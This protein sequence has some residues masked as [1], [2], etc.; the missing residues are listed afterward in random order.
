[1]RAGRL[2]EPGD[3]YLGWAI[4]SAAIALL[5]VAV[6]TGWG[7]SLVTIEST[8]ATPMA[9]VGEVF[10]GEA[11]W[12]RVGTGL[13]SLVL[14]VLSLTV[15]ALVVVLL[16]HQRNGTRVDHLA[17]SM[18]RP[19]DRQLLSSAHLAKDAKRLGVAAVCG[20]GVPIGRAVGANETLGSSW[21]WTQMWIMGP[22]AGKT[23]C[24]CVPQIVSTRGPVLATSNK[25]DL[26]DLTRG[27]RSQSG[28]VWVHDPQGLV[29]EPPSWTW[30]PL[31]YVT[32]VARADEMVSVFAASSRNTDAKT[33]AYFDGMAQSLLS[34]FILA[35]GLTKHQITD[36]YTWLNQ[37]ED[38]TPELLLRKA[39]QSISADLVRSVRELNPKQRDG[40]IGS[41]QPL[42]AWVRDEQIREWVLP[43]D[44]VPEFDPDA[45]VRSRDTLYAISKEGAGS[46]RALTAALTVAV[47]RAAEEFAVAQGGRLREP[48]LLVLDEAANVCRWPALPDLYSHYGS[49]GIVIN[50]ILQSWPQGAAAWGDQGMK[51]MWSAANVRGVGVGTADHEF[52][53]TMSNLIGEHDV[54]TR[55]LSTSSGKGGRS[56]GINNRREKIMDASTF[57][58]L[59]RKRAVIL[60]SGLPPVL[61]KLIHWS[62]LDSAE[63]IEASEQ[64]FNRA[65]EQVVRR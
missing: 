31:S 20:D 46:A 10:A 60:T 64:H 48:L 44:G 3:N 28:K 18:S 25:R 47:T 55:S 33:D 2:A 41:A 61:I 49:R 43:Q 9:W 13:V 23:T 35:A 63:L 45:F 24:V 21:E 30:S 54:R 8:P 7:I 1:M 26:V 12:N 52:A 5:M 37:P 39:G 59:P 27:I 38:E 11:E 51:K 50:T 65:P 53:S 16:K 58:S 34:A 4:A 19:R 57:S 36:V 62:Q 14:V 56:T 32:S 29:N 42:L 22:R 6:V 17:R 40:V 15:A